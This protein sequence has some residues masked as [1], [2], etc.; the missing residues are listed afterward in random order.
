[1]ILVGLLVIYV[2]SML[3]MASD[4]SNLA[5]EEP[6]KDSKESD[7]VDRDSGNKESGSNATN[8]NTQKPDSNN[9]KLN[10]S[11]N[12]SGSNA[13]ES[14]K[15]QENSNRVNNES[16][17]SS[18][19]NASES[20]QSQESNSSE[21]QQSQESNS[22]NSNPGTNQVFKTKEIK[23]SHFDGQKVNIESFFKEPGKEDKVAYYQDF[24]ESEKPRDTCI[25]N[26]KNPKKVSNK[27]LVVDLQKCSSLKYFINQFL[28][29]SFSNKLELITSNPKEIT[30]NP[31]DFIL[32][33]CDENE[34]FFEYCP[35]L[36]SLAKQKKSS[37]SAT[38]III[39]SLTSLSRASGYKKLPVSIKYL[40]KTKK[41]FKDFKF[42]SIPSTNCSETAAIFLYGHSLQLLQS[43]KENSPVQ[44][45]FMHSFAYELE[46]KA[47]WQVFK[48]SGYKT[49]V[50]YDKFP[51]TL[52]LLNE[53]SINADYKI[54][55]YWE[56]I[57]KSKVGCC[58]GKKCD[59][60]HE[61]VFDQ[62]K[63]FIFEEK[64]QSKFIF[65]H[66][67]VDGQGYMEGFDNELK[68]FLKDVTEFVDENQSLG[69]FLVS[70]HGVSNENVKNTVQGYFDKNVPMTFVYSNNM[71]DGY[72]KGIDNT[73]KV[74][75][76][77]DLY[78]TLSE[79]AKKNKTLNTESRSFYEAEKVYNLIEG[80]VTREDCADVLQLNFT[81]PEI[82]YLETSSK[83]KKLLTKALKEYEPIKKCVKDI[84]VKSV[85]NYDIQ[86]DKESTDL[87]EIFFEF[88][89]KPA[90]AFAYR[91]SKEFKIDSVYLL[92]DS[93]IKKLISC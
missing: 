92:E 50:L 56:Q 90:K 33:E 38:N 61:A 51:K 63:N 80:S 49:L 1:M 37:N 70:D 24:D 22:S 83:Q 58:E 86:K 11:T 30:L 88:R 66:F 76:K 71:F 57:G 68:G 31:G 89:K 27:S 78:H 45:S 42:P 26:F 8:S 10:N 72:I 23:I 43:I 19:S 13:S 25:R 84:K 75:T 12:T 73:E 3:Y 85:F 7:S 55:N 81:C 74:F 32:F 36:S 48:N 65:L 41:T 15:A 67:V 34:A 29:T 4:G 35:I 59:K 52:E 18:E 14:N 47:L 91:A 77:F 17:N 82:S 28:G 62:A 21:S 44:Y 40:K 54:V 53:E 39:I 64:D 20:Q 46:K 16:N 79:I 60:R 87:F 5:I 6:I 69:I 93:K 9:P 2:L